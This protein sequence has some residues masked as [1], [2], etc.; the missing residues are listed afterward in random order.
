[1]LTALLT[2]LKAK[3]EE[4]DSQGNTALMTALRN[5]AR[6]CEPLQHLEDFCVL[7]GSS[8]MTGGTLVLC[9]VV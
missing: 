5:T 6:A 2:A 1:M 4:K 8:C 7:L 3:L 9:D